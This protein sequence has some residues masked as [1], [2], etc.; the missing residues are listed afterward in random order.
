[1][2][3]LVEALVNYFLQIIKH[4]NIV[5]QF[6]FNTIR[7]A[8]SVYPFIRIRTIT[9]F[10]SMFLLLCLSPR[11]LLIPSFYRPSRFKKI[12]SV[13]FRR[14]HWFYLIFMAFG[15]QSVL[16]QFPVEFL[17]FVERSLF[18]IS[19]LKLCCKYFYFKWS[20]RTDHYSQD[21]FL[22]QWLNPKAWLA[23]V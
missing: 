21:G 11:V 2:K 19:G 9:M 4:V 5:A 10:A 7:W 13:Y 20:C 8:Y 1:M 23:C 22:L 12:G 17:R 14:Y 16:T 6:L 15:L 3:Q 18:V